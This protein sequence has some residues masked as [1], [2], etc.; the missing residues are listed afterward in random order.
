MTDINTLLDAFE[1]YADA[2]RD[3]REAIAGCREDAG[4]FCHREYD[5]RDKT[6]AALQAA[7]DSYIDGRVRACL[8][9]HEGE[10]ERTP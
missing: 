1:A 3:L 6:L 9:T 2:R 7:L 10:G 4:Y 8:M 5:R